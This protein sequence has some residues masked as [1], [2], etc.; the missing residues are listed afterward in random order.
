MLGKFVFGLVLAIGL[1]RG[2]H[3]TII[4][5][6]TEFI[7]NDGLGGFETIGSSTW[8]GHQRYTPHDGG[9]SAQYVGTPG[10][11]ET[12]FEPLEGRYSW[13]PIDG[14]MGYTSI[15]LNSNNWFTAI[16]FQA[17]TSLATGAT[18]LYE[19]LLQGNVLASGIAGYL[20][21]YPSGGSWFGFLSYGTFMDEIRLQAVY[22]GTS[23]DPMAH[24][25]LVLDSISAV[26]EPTT[27]AL[28][29]VGFC[30]LSFLAYRHRKQVALSA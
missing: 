24:D 12:Q 27:W 14:S 10:T 18:L 11:I 13:H 29:L 28:M 1:V 30:G 19:V 3:A 20:P 9:P 8:N 17:A 15:K 25:S 5:E 4:V 16:D 26:P 21:S 6:T 23:F 7:G 22:G 2:A